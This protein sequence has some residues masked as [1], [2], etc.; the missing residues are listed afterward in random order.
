[1]P[2]VSEN[3]KN[4]RTDWD[5]SERGEEWSRWWGGTPAQWYGVILPR[6]HA[7]IP[8]G[9]ILEI[10]PGYGRWTQYLKDVCDRLAVVDLTEACIEHCRTRF[11]AASHISYHVNDGRSLEMIEDHS[12][13]F[14][15]SFDSLVHVDPGVIGV[16]VEQLVDKL[17]PRGVGFLHHSN[18]GALRPV[19]AL[20]RRLPARLLGP[21]S[22][23]G[24]ALNLA[25]WRDDEMTAQRFR[26]QCDAVGLACVAQ[27]LVSWEHGGYLIDCFSIFTRRGSVWD[28]PLQRVR[29]PLFVAEASRMARLYAATSFT[30]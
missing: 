8:T 14:V 19:S 2:N 15:F 9:T 28:R 23:R 18:A 24:I 7:M 12:I 1:M 11:A 22:R 30:V 20:S 25:A 3:L 21:L 27:E 13:D 29:N 16:Y 4:W 26:A 10:A 5:W 6:I 17:T